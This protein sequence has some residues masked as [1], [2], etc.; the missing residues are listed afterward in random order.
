MGAAAANIVIMVIIV[1]IISCSDRF[2]EV[3]VSATLAA[4]ATAT[5]A[6]RIYQH[7]MECCGNWLRNFLGFFTYCVQDERWQ[8]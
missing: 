7:R 5:W 6:G 8:L 3:A 1:V 4:E 2:L